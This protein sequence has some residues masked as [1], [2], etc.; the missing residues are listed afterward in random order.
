MVMIANHEGQIFK[1]KVQQGHK[2]LTS[3][4]LQRK[5]RTLPMTVQDAVELTTSFFIYV[6]TYHD[7]NFA[8]KT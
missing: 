7:N 1:K 6:I 4:P 3:S 8:Y 2:I 5:G